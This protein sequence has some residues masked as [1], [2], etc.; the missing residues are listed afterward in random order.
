M[1]HLSSFAVDP[2]ASQLALLNLQLCVYL[3][4]RGVNW[5][6]RVLFRHDPPKKSIRS[7][8][9]QANESKLTGPVKPQR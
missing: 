5:A 6:G 1:D 9:A 3:C 8:L 4:C 7:T 2:V